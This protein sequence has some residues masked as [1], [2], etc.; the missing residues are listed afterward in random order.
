MGSVNGSDT[1]Q[2]DKIIKD[3]EV[4]IEPYMFSKNGSEQSLPYPDLF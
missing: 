2:F 3:E 1:S 4:L